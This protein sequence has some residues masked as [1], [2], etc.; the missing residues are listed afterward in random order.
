MLPVREK[1]GCSAIWRDGNSRMCAYRHLVVW[2]VDYSVDYSVDSKKRRP[3]VDDCGEM[4][5]S[6]VRRA[7][8]TLNLLY[9]GDFGSQTI[10]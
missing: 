6:W 3:V 9:G 5:G 7:G 4:I 1:R 8:P 10:I 2:R